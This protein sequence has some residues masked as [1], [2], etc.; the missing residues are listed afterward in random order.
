[1]RPQDLMFYA[2]ADIL[3]AR[4]VTINKANGT[5][6]YTAGAAMPDGVVEYEVSSGKPATV[7][8]IGSKRREFWVTAG[9]NITKGAALEVGTNGQVITRTAG[10]ICG[11]A[12]RTV[13]TGEIF[14][15]YY[16]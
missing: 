5:V 11:Y 14:E 10:Q 7:Y 6:A 1:M 3:A 9:A 16:V 2:S 13:V 15:A 8:P 12:T 4:M